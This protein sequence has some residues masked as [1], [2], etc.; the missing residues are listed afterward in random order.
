[1][2]NGEISSAA[3]SACE[4]WLSIWMKTITRHNSAEIFQLD[5]I[6]GFVMRADASVEETCRSSCGNKPTLQSSSE[7]FSVKLTLCHFSTAGSIRQA[8]FQQR[9]ARQNKLH[10]ALMDYRTIAIDHQ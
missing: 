2:C 6:A 7:C 1:M 8:A 5:E 3:G 10:G 9:L 4:R